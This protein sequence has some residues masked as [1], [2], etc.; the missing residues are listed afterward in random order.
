MNNPTSS[1][2]DQTERQALAAVASHPLRAEATAWPYCEVDVAEWEKAFVARLRLPDD[3]KAGIQSGLEAVET[4]LV[5]TYW[6]SERTPQPLSGGGKHYSF[7][8][9][10]R[11]FAVLHSGVGTWRS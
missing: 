4:V 5:V 10:P 3:E 11:S 2:S 9:H 1:V 8:V 7:F 6:T